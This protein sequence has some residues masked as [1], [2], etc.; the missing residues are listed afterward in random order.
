MRYFRLSAARS[1]IKNSPLELEIL[2]EQEDCRRS[3]SAGACVRQWPEVSDF[4]ARICTLRVNARV[5]KHT[6]MRELHAFQV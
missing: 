3:G 4:V 1:A 5:R 2:T 6:D